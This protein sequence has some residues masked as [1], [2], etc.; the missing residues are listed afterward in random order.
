MN[1]L[2]P[3]YAN[4]FQELCAAM[5]LFYLE[6]REMRAVLRAQ[7]RLLDGSCA[8]MEKLVAVNFILTADE[9]TI[10]LWEQALKVIGNSRLTLDQRRR[11]VIGYIIGLGH[12]GEPEIREII[13]QYTPN[14]VDFGFMRGTISVQIEGEVFDEENLLETLLRRIP[15]HLTLKMRVHKRREFRQALY[16]GFAGAIGTQQEPQFVAEPRS[17]TLEIHIS[18]GGATTPT[19]TGEPHTQPRTATRP[20]QVGYGGSLSPQFS[21]EP[22]TEPRTALSPLLVGHSGALTPS[23]TAEPPEVKRASTGLKTGGRGVF[24]QTRIKS[25]LIRTEE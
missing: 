23:I 19:I 4:N 7:G 24:F 16:I 5:P 14:R 18:R 2:N 8:G 15:T 25:K 22:H 20:V 3:P 9:A 13:G 10:R 12:I 1:Y 17:S 21:P 6:V 11:V